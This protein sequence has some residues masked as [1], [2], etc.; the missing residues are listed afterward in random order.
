MCT[1]AVLLV[2]ST[3]LLRVWYGLLLKSSI[4]WERRLIMKTLC[5]TGLIKCVCMQCWLC[6]HLHCPYVHM[7]SCVCVRG[8]CTGGLFRV[9]DYLKRRNKHSAVMFLS[10]ID[11]N[12]VFCLMS[13]CL[14]TQCVPEQYS[15]VLSGHY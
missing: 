3:Y 8:L 6:V 1:C 14:Q 15:C 11:N 4:D 5:T 7:C 12:C 10:I 13:T 2:Y 9:M